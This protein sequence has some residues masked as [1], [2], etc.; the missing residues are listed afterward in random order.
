MWLVLLL[1][2]SPLP[3]ALG[4]NLFNV[5]PS[6]TYASLINK[7]EVSILWLNSAFAIALFNTFN[8]TGEAALFVNN[9]TACASLTSKPRTKSITKRAFLGATLT[10]LAIA[11]ASIINYLPLQFQLVLVLPF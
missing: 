9:N 2:M 3:L 11:L 6:V 1:I 8:I 7:F 4:N 10:D 5:I